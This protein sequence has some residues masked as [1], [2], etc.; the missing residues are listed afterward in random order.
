MTLIRHKHVKIMYNLIENIH[1]KSSNHRNYTKKKTAETFVVFFK[2]LE[3]FEK[4][5][6]CTV[7]FRCNKKQRE[8][9]KCQAYTANN[10]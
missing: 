5:Q 10:Q 6:V 7:F 3:N 2:N 9:S 1:K 8:K 4:L